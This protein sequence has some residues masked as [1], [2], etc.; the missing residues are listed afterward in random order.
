VN[1][2]IRQSNRQASVDK[3]AAQYRTVAVHEV[4]G[5]SSALLKMVLEQ[6]VTTVSDV[7]IE[8]TTAG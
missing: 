1:A 2:Q 5:G 7:V 6:N 4:E 3:G 8:A